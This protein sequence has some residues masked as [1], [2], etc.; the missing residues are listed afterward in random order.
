ML[1]ISVNTGDV[2]R[3]LRRLSREDAPMVT[4]YA[5]TKTGQSGEF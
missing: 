5:L 4:A 2:M 3:N 1:R